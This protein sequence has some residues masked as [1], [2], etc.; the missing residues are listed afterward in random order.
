MCQSLCSSWQSNSHDLLGWRCDD[1][2]KRD[3]ESLVQEIF[4]FKIDLFMVRM[5]E[6]WGSLSIG[7]KHIPYSWVPW[8]SLVHWQCGCCSESFSHTCKLK[9]S[10]TLSFS[11]DHFEKL[12]KIIYWIN[13]I[14]LIGR[15]IEWTILGIKKSERF[16][17]NTRGRSPW[18]RICGV[19]FE[20]EE[21]NL[22]SFM[23]LNKY[24]NE[25]VSVCEFHFEK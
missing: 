9:F 4:I 22:K 13:L 7:G 2:R 21:V 24:H 10:S 3:W 16:V 23:S 17:Q 8:S 18:E 1:E 15:W 12:L 14:V 6:K 19:S 20:L 25:F 11:N 5:V